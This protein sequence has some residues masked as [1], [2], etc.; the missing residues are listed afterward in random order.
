V[1]EHNTIVDNA[2]Q[3]ILLGGTAVIRHNILAN[4]LYGIYYLDDYDPDLQ[5]YV[6]GRLT[7]A[8]NDLWNHSDAD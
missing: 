1:I 4:A 8:F 5:N 3:N 6:A 2:R 7:V